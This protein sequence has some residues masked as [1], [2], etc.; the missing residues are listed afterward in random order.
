[1]EPLLQKIDLKS[2]R[3]YS[4][5]FCATAC[6]SVLLSVLA[7]S[8]CNWIKTTSNDTN[9]E[10]NGLFVREKMNLFLCTNDMSVSECG[11]LQ[12]SKVSSIVSGLFGMASIFVVI[13]YLR[14]EGYLTSLGASIASVF[15]GC[16]FV[17]S[18]ICIVSGWLA[19]ILDFLSTPL[20]ECK[21]FLFIYR[22]IM[23]I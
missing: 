6:T 19:L 16:Q 3:K 13:R 9:P 5:V 7:L 17:F 14:T 11:Y 22:C 12:A 20:C 4:I 21:I 23:T 2:R 10:Y 15:G 8:V 18:L 1:M